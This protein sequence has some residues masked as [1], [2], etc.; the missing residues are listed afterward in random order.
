MIAKYGRKFLILIISLI[1]YIGVTIY[2]L[3]NAVPDT[4]TILVSVATGLTMITGAYFAGNVA[5]KNKV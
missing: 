4:G 3:L 2:C 1:F 5:Q